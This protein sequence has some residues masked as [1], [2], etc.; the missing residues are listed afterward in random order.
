MY[1]IGRFYGTGE[2]DASTV[3]LQKYSQSFHFYILGYS[4]DEMIIKIQ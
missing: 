2:G 3:S 1:L 4:I